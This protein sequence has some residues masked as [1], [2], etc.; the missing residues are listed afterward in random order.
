MPCSGAPSQFW[1]ARNT[2]IVGVGS[3][4]LDNGG[5]PLRGGPLV[6]NS[7]NGSLGQNWVSVPR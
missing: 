6:I 3:R 5:D 4:C 1:T 2:S 7:C